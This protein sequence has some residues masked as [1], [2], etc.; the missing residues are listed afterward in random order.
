MAR[1]VEGL[2]AVAVGVSKLEV[3]FS[4][5]LNTD[6]TRIAEV[7]FNGEWRSARRKQ[8]YKNVCVVEWLRVMCSH[9]AAL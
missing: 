9:I 7:G 8:F 6:E 5:G 4:H 1:R 3:R 2:K